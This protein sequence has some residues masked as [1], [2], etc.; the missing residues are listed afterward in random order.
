[1][2]I[3]EE[4]ISMCKIDKSKCKKQNKQFAVNNKLSSA[5]KEAEGAI[6]YS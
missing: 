1:M 6:S 5:L 4:K 2:K 3:I